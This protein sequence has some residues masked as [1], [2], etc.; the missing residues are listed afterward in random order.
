M[1]TP[2]YTNTW[3]PNYPKSKAK[4]V[5]LQ[6][7]EFSTFIS[8]RRPGII[9]QDYPLENPACFW[10]DYKHLYLRTNWTTWGTVSLSN[11]EQVV[12]ICD[13]HY[14]R[15]LHSANDVTSDFIVP[16]YRIAALPGNLFGSDDI[17]KSKSNGVVLGRK[18]EYQESIDLVAKIANKVSKDL[19]IFPRVTLEND[20]CSI[21]ISNDDHAVI[22]DI[23]PED[24]DFVF[25]PPDEDDSLSFADK[26]PTDKVS[27][28]FI[29][30]LRRMQKALSNMEPTSTIEIGF[31]AN[32]RMIITL[33]GILDS[34]GI[35]DLIMVSYVNLKEDLTAV[36]GENNPL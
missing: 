31:L 27:L 3:T 33:E 8:D 36:F 34:M 22:M 15:I 17:L 32:T 10:I 14:C 12:A 24:R 26:W 7:C 1:K 9:V 35:S 6:D 25:T 2:Q 21:V 4:K 11:P 5:H 28:S 30:K 20:M 18:E 23:L 29:D 16:V 19:E 13:A